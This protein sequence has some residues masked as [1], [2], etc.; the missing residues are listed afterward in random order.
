[1]NSTADTLMMSPRGSLKPVAEATI[2]WI[3]AMRALTS[4]GFAS[5]PRI[6]ASR[7]WL[8]TT[9]IDILVSE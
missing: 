6:A 5:L 7:V 2:F 8:T 4:S 3:S 1:M 9:E